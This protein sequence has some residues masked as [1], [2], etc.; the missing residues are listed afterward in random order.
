[1]RFYA[2][3][4][5]APGI[6]PGIDQWGADRALAEA[7]GYRVIGGTT[8]YSNLD[9]NDLAMRYATTYNRVLLRHFHAKPGKA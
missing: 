9:L 6:I 8:D 3:N 4:G 1:L 7:H 5:I 2:V